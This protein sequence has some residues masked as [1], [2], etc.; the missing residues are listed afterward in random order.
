[1]DV[2]QDREFTRKQGYIGSLQESSGPKLHPSDEDESKFFGEF[3]CKSQPER[4]AQVQKKGRNFRPRADQH[5]AAPKLSERPR[6]NCTRLPNTSTTKTKRKTPSY[7][8][9][10]VSWS[11]MSHRCLG[12]VL[13]KFFSYFWPFC[14]RHTNSVNS[15]LA[16]TLKC[17]TGLF[18]ATKREKAGQPMRNSN[19]YFTAKPKELGRKRLPLLL[20][21]RHKSIAITLYNSCELA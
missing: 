6:R 19:H 20:R 8:M 21:P 1:M 14:R 16:H 13:A 10:G 11:S 7:L 12:F 5:R 3:L 17:E 2:V 18:C 9:P 4:G 15:N